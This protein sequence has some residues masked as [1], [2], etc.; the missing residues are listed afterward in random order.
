V[1]FP[2]AISTSICRSN[3]TICSGLYLF[4][5]MTSLP[6]SEFSLI[7][8]GTKNPGQVKA[9]RPVIEDPLLA[10]RVS[11]PVL[12]EAPGP[13]GAACA[14]PLEQLG[15]SVRLGIRIK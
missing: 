14:G 9:A 6:P 15:F 5:G 4:I 7:S 11:P 10:Y 13:D 12:P 3:A 2:L 1:G 8:P